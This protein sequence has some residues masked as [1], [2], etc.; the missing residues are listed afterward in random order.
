MPKTDLKTERQE[1]PLHCKK[2]IHI[3]RVLLHIF[4]DVAYY[5]ILPYLYHLKYLIVCK[6]DFMYHAYLPIV[7]KENFYFLLKFEKIMTF[8]NNKIIHQTYYLEELSSL[9]LV[10]ES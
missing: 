3:R 1:R 9:M 7:D 4:H 2:L 8:G 10:E 5:Y 6:L